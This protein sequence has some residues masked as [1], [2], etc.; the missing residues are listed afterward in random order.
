VPP[1]AAAEP[2]SADN[3]P[4]EELAGEPLDFVLDENP[5]ALAY[6][7]VPVVLLELVAPA[8]AVELLPEDV[9]MRCES[10]LSSYGDR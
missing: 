2:R 5:D 10:R 9:P 8:A 3:V 6:G 7:V 1:G 4:D